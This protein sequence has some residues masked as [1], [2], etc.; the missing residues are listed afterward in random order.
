MAKVPK[1][2]KITPRSRTTS[3]TLPGVPF[4]LPKASPRMKQRASRLAEL[5]AE[6]YPAAYCELN[7]TTPH[8]LLIATILSAQT[9]DVGVNRCTPALFAAFPTPAD[10]A[11][12][13]PAQI[14]PHIRTIGLFRSKAKAVHQTMA[15]LVSNFGGQ[16]PSDMDSLITLR[17]VARKTASV[18]LGNCFNINVGFVTDTHVHRL[19]QRLGLVPRGTPV[20]K[21]ERLIMAAFADHQSQW[22]DLSHRLIFHGRRAC[23]AR[24]GPGP[25]GQTGC[26][27][28]HPI[29]RELGEKCELRIT[30]R[31]RKAKAN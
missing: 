31:P 16:V 2:S 17:G 8:E 1:P 26:C 5:L 6:H 28:D 24:G 7:Y 22:K 4:A 27:A 25:N 21:A 9:T 3:S 13:T 29:C 15:M 18:V 20:P 11:L 19:S 10:Y 14:E 30:A 23:K 12:T